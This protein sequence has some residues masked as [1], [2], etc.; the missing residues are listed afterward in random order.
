MK[1][2]KR[3]NEELH[4]DTY[5]SAANKLKTNHPERYNKLKEFALRKKDYGT[6]NLIKSRNDYNKGPGQDILIGKY[7]LDFFGLDIDFLQDNIEEGWDGK[8]RGIIIFI[9]FKNDET[10]AVH[11]S[12]W[13]KLGMNVFVPYRNG[14]FDKA[15]IEFQNTHFLFADRQSVH[16]FKRAIEDRIENSFVNYNDVEVFPFK[17][18]TIMQL[19]DLS[20]IDPEFKVTDDQVDDFFENIKL[21]HIS[22]ND[23]YSTRQ[24]R[25]ELPQ[26]IR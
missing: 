19:D 7:K 2:L 6:F 11:T 10:G 14:N 20:K 25:F 26:V 21:K 18:T 23:L 24:D 16:K 4:L 1:Y 3:F 8:V 5:L 13:Y 9:I 17:E 22:N 15:I 12:D